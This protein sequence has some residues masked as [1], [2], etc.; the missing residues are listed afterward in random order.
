MT[1]YV[2]AVPRWRY[3]FVSVAVVDGCSPHGA[4]IC[5]AIEDLISPEPQIL[6]NDCLNAIQRIA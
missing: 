5:E 3:D 4:A 2:A 6:F 1:R